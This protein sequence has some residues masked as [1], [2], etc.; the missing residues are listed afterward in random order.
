MM[1][2]TRR[3]SPAK[4]Y[5]HPA[6]KQRLERIVEAT[7]RRQTMSSLLDES[8]EIALEVLEKKYGTFKK[9]TRNTPGSN[10]A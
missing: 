9:P 2:M 3:E 4:A 7:S 5:L 8:A 10:A 1:A 6:R